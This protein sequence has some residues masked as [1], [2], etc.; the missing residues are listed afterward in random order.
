[1]NRDS[2]CLRFS[3]TE[4][5]HDGSADRAEHFRLAPKTRHLRVNESM[6]QGVDNR[7]L[8]GRGRDLAIRSAA[9]PLKGFGSLL[10]KRLKGLGGVSGLRE[11]AD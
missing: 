7:T 2:V 1:M 4:A 11:R 10:L 3:A 9:L 6:P 8:G 5:R